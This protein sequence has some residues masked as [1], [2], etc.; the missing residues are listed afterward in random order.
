VIVPT[1]PGWI[2]QWY[3]KFP[4]VLNV[5]VELALGA[6]FPVSNEFESDVDVCVTVSPFTHVTD[7]P[8]A[9]VTGLGLKAVVVF[10]LAPTVIDTSVPVGVGVVLLSSP[11]PASVTADNIATTNI[12]RR[13]N[14]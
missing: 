8:R 14:M 2:V 10:V 6:I 11:H 7:V 5:T 4:A 9:M 12:I 3:A 13:M 1:I